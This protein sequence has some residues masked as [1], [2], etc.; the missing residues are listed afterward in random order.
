MTMRNSLLIALLLASVSIAQEKP[1][2]PKPEPPAE[3]P[4]A[5][6]R[7]GRPRPAPRLGPAALSLLESAASGVLL[8]SLV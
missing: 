5:A 1:A 6:S 7:A 2:A 4:P 3:A 8:A